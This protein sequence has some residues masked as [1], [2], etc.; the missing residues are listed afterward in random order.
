[1][2]AGGHITA[3]QETA[4]GCF[5]R[6]QSRV[7]EEERACATAAAGR[8]GFFLDLE[9][10]FALDFALDPAPDL[11]PDFAVVRAP[12]SGVLSRV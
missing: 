12:R 11:A 10:D 8:A 5:K 3:N 2:Q 9:L 1:M 6:G 4:G 7:A